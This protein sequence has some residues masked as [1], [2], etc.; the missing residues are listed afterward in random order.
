MQYSS[1]IDD[2]K[3]DTDDELNTERDVHIELPIQDSALHFRIFNIQ[4]RDKESK[5]DAKSILC[6]L[7]KVQLLLDSI[8]IAFNEELEGE[9]KTL[10]LFIERAQ[11]IKIIWDFILASFRFFGE[12]EGIPKKLLRRVEKTGHVFCEKLSTPNQ[13]K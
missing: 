11:S 6:D 13:Y 1:F 12:S 3:L 5:E 2:L 8:P 7:E 9:L 10:S 4:F